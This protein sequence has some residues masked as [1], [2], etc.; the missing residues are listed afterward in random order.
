[1]S[2]AAINTGCEVSKLLN[3]SEPQFPQLLKGDNN[4]T[5]LIELLGGI[6][7]IMYEQVGMQQEVNKY[8][9]VLSLGAM[10]LAHLPVPQ[11]MTKPWRK[12]QKSTPA[13]SGSSGLFLP[14]DITP[15]PLIQP[16]W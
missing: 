9:Q 13:H 8:W 4:K 1:M 12:R 6:S 16:S 15:M 2:I 7:E 3:A 14:W 5:Y 10:L 11:K